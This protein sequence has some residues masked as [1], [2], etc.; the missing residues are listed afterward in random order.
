MVIISNCPLHFYF[1]PL[2]W[3]SSETS[4]W[5]TFV[6]WMVVNEEIQVIKSKKL[7]IVSTHPEM[8][9][10]YPPYTHQGLESIME[11]GKGSFW[12]S[13]A[14]KE[15]ALW[16]WQDR[17]AHKLTTAVTACTDLHN[18]EPINLLPWKL[19]RFMSPKP[20]PK[21]LFVY[22][23][24]LRRESVFKKEHGIWVGVNRG[25]SGKSW[26]KYECDYDQIILHKTLKEL[27]KVF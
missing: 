25:I 17:C 11:E 21:E 14:Q 20:P 8:G 27:I 18:I 24:F 13:E 1:L 23:D 2:D 26:G 3:C 16:I 6:Y 22:N 10:Q 4:L 15:H 7:V 12:E 5:S 9:H 19:K